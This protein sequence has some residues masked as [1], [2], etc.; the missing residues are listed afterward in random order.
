M[1]ITVELEVGEARRAMYALL[2]NAS[3]LRELA[4]G[5]HAGEPPTAALLGEVAASLGETAFAIEQAIE[6]VK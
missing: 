5:F 3:T 6:K 1:K 4:H 2:E